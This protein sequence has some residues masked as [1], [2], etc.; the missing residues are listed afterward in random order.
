MVGCA[1]LLFFVYLHVLSA[2]TGLAL[3][4]L[5][6]AS[7]VIYYIS[8]FRGQTILIAIAI[9]LI[10][11]ASWLVLPTLQNRIR[12]NL[13]DLSHIQHHTYRSGTSDG[14]RL[15]SLK[16]GCSIIGMHPFGVGAGDVRA[17]ANAWYSEHVPTMQDSD[18]IY[19]SSEWIVYGMMAGWPGIVLF[20][21]IILYPVFLKEMA[22]RFFWVSLCLLAGLSFVI[23]TS[24]E[25]QYGVFIY[26]FVLLWWWKWLT[27]EKQITLKHD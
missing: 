21:L 22:S 25:I 15:I 14:N 4:Y 6:L 8:G 10:A 20:T 2:R 27:F 7:Y 17:A 12:Y 18:K 24:L 5:F 26:S 9:A 13:Y 11:L 19:P 23:E 16:A 1:L 3:T